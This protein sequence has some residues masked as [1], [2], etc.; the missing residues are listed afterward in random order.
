MFLKPS[1]LLAHGVRGLLMIVHFMFRCSAN[2]NTLVSKAM[3]T[4][5]ALPV[6]L[7]SISTVVIRSENIL[8]SID[9]CHK[10]RTNML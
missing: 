8:N 9:L 5:S 1:S 3:Y 2:Q 10:T 4:S 6:T 7:I